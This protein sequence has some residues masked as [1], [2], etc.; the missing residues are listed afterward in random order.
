MSTIA[1]HLT[2]VMNCLQNVVYFLLLASFVE[3]G[4]FFVCYAAKQVSPVDSWRGLL[5]N[6]WYG[7]LVLVMMVTFKNTLEFLLLFENAKRIKDDSTAGSTTVCMVDKESVSFRHVDHRS[8]EPNPSWSAI[9]SFMLATWIADS[10]KASTPSTPAAEPAA[11]EEP[12]ANES[13]ATEQ[14]DIKQDAT[15]ASSSARSNADTD[16]LN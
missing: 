11:E 13:A 15:S 12:V 8:T 6:M 1:T 5:Y 7:A 9:A 14:D 2:T 10:K 16:A 3:T 4:M